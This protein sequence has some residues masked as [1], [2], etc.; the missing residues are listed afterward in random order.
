M[1]GGHSPEVFVSYNAREG[2]SLTVSDGACKSLVTEET[3]IILEVGFPRFGVLAF[4]EPKGIS[5]VLKSESPGDPEVV[6][7]ANTVLSVPVSAATITDICIIVRSLAVEIL[8][9]EPF[10]HKTSVLPA[11]FPS[12]TCTSSLSSLTISSRKRRN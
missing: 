2:N 12:A 8:K 6:L 10:N 1:L 11:L 7:L 4:F 9:N 3:R 5:L